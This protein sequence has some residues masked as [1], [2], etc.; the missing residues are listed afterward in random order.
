MIGGLLRKRCPQVGQMG[1]P[2]SVAS[3]LCV[4]TLAQE[5]NEEWR[6]V[7]VFC[8]VGSVSIAKQVR[9]PVQGNVTS[10]LMEQY[11]LSGKVDRFLVSTCVLFK[12]TFSFCRFLILAQETGLRSRSRSMS[13][14]SW[15]ARSTWFPRFSSL[16]HREIRESESS[17]LQAL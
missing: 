17:R 16:I 8:M 13:A 14:S 15:F 4:F 7:F 12:F 6:K 1:L 5:F 10:S 3:C 11:D 2:R 9:V